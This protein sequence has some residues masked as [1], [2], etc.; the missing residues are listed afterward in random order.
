MSSVHSLSDVMKNQNYLLENEIMKKKYYDR[1]KIKKQEK[2]V[3]QIAKALEK[4]E[5]FTGYKSFKKIEG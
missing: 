3:N 4:F 2:T 5:E 1:L